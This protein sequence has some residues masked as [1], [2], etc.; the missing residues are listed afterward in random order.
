MYIKE[1][2]LLATWPALISASY[3]IIKLVIKK[4]EISE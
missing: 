1:I 2:I 4:I 3:F